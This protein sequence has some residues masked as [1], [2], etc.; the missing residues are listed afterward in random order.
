MPVAEKKTEAPSQFTPYQP[1]PGEEYMNENQ[2]KHLFSIAASLFNNEFKDK[3][4]AI[5]G[6]S[7]KPKTDD[8]RGAPSL[9]IIKKLLDS[10]AEVECYDPIVSKDSEKFEIQNE[11][12]RLGLHDAFKSISIQMPSASSWPHGSDILSIFKEL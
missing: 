11:S 10:G 6:L 9:T 8:M 5:W 3:K 2:K 7:F 4:V 12:L 1:A